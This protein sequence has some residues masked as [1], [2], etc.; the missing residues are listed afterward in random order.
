MKQVFRM[1]RPIMPA[2]L[3]AIIVAVALLA[4]AI[5]IIDTV[6][7]IRATWAGQI[8]PARYTELAAWG[9]RSIVEAAQA[10]SWRIWLAHPGDALAASIAVMQNQYAA[11][12]ITTAMTRLTTIVIATALGAG[13]VCFV[14]TF[15]VSSK[16]D[17]VRHLRGFRLLRDWRAALAFRRAERAARRSTG[18]GIRLAPGMTISRERESRHFLV[19]GATGSG[20]SVIIRSW[21]RQILRRGDRVLLHDT[22]GDVLETMPV[23]DFVLLAPH[24]ARSAVWNVAADIVTEE[25]AREFAACLVPD[26][27]DPV[28]AAGA[29]ELFTGA[30][31]I[32]QKTRQ[33]AWGW[34]ELQEVLLMDPVQLRALLSRHYRPGATYIILSNGSPSKT[35]MSFFSTLE[36]HVNGT[37][38]PLS[39]AWH[40]PAIPRVSAREFLLSDSRDKRIMIVQRAAHLPALSTAWIGAFVR[41][42]ANLSVGPLL[43]DDA[44]RRIWF[45][46]DEFPQLGKLNGF[47]Q[48]LEKGRSRGLCCIL[49]AQDIS[50]LSGLYGADV[51]KTWL[52]SIG[53]KIVC[54][55]EVGATAKTICDEWAGTRQVAWTERSWSHGPWKLELG[56]QAT[57]SRQVHHRDVAVLQPSELQTT[58]GR[59]DRWPVPTVSALVFG[60][61]DAIISAEWPIVPWPKLRPGSE[62][63]KHL[64]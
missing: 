18:D 36:A 11:A 59:K 28:W 57:L 10:I 46:L 61:G 7:P 45:M 54:R 23:A 52:S 51:T 29:R 38:R 30:V 22:K 1:R 33:Q 40:D 27:Q 8:W 56:S 47:A 35:M 44:K 16:R 3:S 25:D 17:R 55:M 19:V 64:S 21:L 41:V 15:V 42:A 32:L 48:I 63:G 5:A 39:H 34:S 43:P 50:Q 4:A 62:P 13:L 6:A 58:L 9:F 31:V 24:D 37:V 2:L 26:S 14:V 53:T 20:K 12:G 60:V 49:G